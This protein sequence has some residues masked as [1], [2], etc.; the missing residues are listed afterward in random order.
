MGYEWSP[1]I[2]AG[3]EVLPDGYRTLVSSARRVFEHDDRVRA[4]WLHGAIARSGAD[5]ASDMDIDIAVADEDFDDFAAAWTT[6]LA[7]ITPTVS[8]VPLPGMPGSLY[9]LTPA[10]E[11]MDV[12]VERVSATSTSPLTRRLVVFD[13]DDLTA[14]VPE[15]ADPPPDRKVMRHYI[16]EMLRQAAN[17]MTVV[18]RGDVLL[19]V[20][21]V[22]QIH[23]YLYLLFAE[24]S[25]PQPPT[26]PKQWSF[27]LS[28]RHRLLLEG[29]PIATP[30]L[31]SIVIA[32][33]AALELL[34]TEGRSVAVEH[35]VEWPTELEEAV[36]SYLDKV[37]HGVAQTG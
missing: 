11:R 29:L 31:R 4:M 26:G 30:D 9:A 6:W 20:V 24:S 18:E 23:Q 7:D 17:F 36:L 3:L 14:A 1:E 33:Q 25:K 15:P 16:E 12:I 21:A 19:G 13:H 2:E 37:G 32:R 34:L 8:A 27:K 10:C 35:G 22:Q 28:E 5:R